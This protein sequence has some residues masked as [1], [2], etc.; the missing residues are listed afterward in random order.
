MLQR[1]RSRAIPT[2]SK[3]LSTFVRSFALVSKYAAFLRLADIQS[4]TS[5]SVTTLAIYHKDSVKYICGRLK[6][7]AYIIINNTANNKV[8]RVLLFCEV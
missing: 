3:R 4:T 1:A 8:Q 7:S 5:L 2:A 6:M